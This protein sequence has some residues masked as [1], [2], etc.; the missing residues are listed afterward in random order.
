MHDIVSSA[1][2][3]GF[4]VPR[5]GDN[6]HAV[7]SALLAHAE[8][9]RRLSL[10]DFEELPPAAA[11]DAWWLQTYFALCG[12]NSERALSVPSTFSRLRCPVLGT[13]FSLANI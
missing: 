4:S 13:G 1:L 11:N 2:A 3:L 12:V 9:L 10:D 5:P 7:L 6:V 8:S